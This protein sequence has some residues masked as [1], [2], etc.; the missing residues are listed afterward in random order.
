MLNI[1]LDNIIDRYK[2]DISAFNSLDVTE[3]AK[4]L[5][6]DCGHINAINEHAYPELLH[7]KNACIDFIKNMTHADNDA[8]TIATS[9]SSEAILIRLMQLQRCYQSTFN[10]VVGSSGHVSWR[11]L[12][13]YLGI[14]VRV[15]ETN[16]SGS[17]DIDS[18]IDLID[19]NTK[20]IVTTLGSPTTLQFDDV[21]AL[22]KAIEVYPDLTI[23]VDAAIGGFVAPFIDL[24]EWD[25]RLKRVA[26]INISAHKYGIVNPALGFLISRDFNAMKSNH[27]YFGEDISHYP[28]RFSYSCVPILQLY[29]NIISLGIDGYSE[30]IKEHYR[31]ADKVNHY[32]QRHYELA[33]NLD[34]RNQLPGLVYIISGKSK[35]QVLG[36]SWN[37]SIY[38]LPNTDESAFRVVI[39]YGLDSEQ[40]LQ[41]LQQH[42]Y[43]L[44]TI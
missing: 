42:E 1:E 27:N 20:M 36:D 10:I 41:V 34:S 17:V 5:Q 40:L 9:G 28:L 14:E 33:Y 3:T 23:H 26:S 11:H 38:N 13:T 18:V 12:G 6:K 21:A 30:I 29:D 43:E 39:K 4:Q 32:L 7:I 19:I 16:S 8:Q 44:A 2:K 35:E 25:F 37:V 22:D 31:L 24:Q 15:A